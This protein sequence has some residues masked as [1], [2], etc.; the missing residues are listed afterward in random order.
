[1]ARSEG[2][3]HRKL[4]PDAVIH[5]RQPVKPGVTDEET[6]EKG[7]EALGLE[8]LAEQISAL[9][10]TIENRTN[11]V[12]EYNS[13]PIT[14]AGS[15]SAVV[16]QPTYEY[17][18]EK[19]EAIIVAGPAGNIT[20]ILGDR[21]LALTIPTTGYLILAPVAMLLGRSDTR[22][23]QAATPGLYF[24]ELMGIADRRFKI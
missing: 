2:L 16:V 21:Q 8:Q 15:A 12:D 23:L 10:R 5:T 11:L 7:F 20:L 17:M 9:A 6:E 24:L 14:G 18:P 3:I 13:A 22:S 19:I 4:P 1:M